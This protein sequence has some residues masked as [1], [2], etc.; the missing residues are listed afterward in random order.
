[1]TVLEMETHYS[2]QA[3]AKRMQG[4]ENALKQ[5]NELKLLEL[6]LL[7]TQI[8]REQA[9]RSDFIALPDLT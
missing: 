1:M 9:L 2:I 3:M 8:A 4:I 5:A 7:R 6:H